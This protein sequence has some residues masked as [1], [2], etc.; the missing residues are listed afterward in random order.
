MVS[1]GAGTGLV[2]RSSALARRFDELVLLSLEPR[3]AVLIE[4]SYPRQRPR[5]A[6]C[7]QLSEELRRVV[8]ALQP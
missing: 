6:A 2:D 7:N 8:Q 5:S 3:I 4:L 1:E